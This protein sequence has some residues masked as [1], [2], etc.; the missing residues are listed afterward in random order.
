MKCQ[1]TAVAIILV[2]SLGLSTRTLA[3]TPPKPIIEARLTLLTRTFHEGDRYKVKIEVENVSD[4]VLL[5][6]RDLN[7]ISN[8][9][10]RMEIQLEDSSGNNYGKGGAAFIDPPP[11]ADLSLKDGILRWWMPLEP[12][13]FMGI[14]FRPKLAGVPPGKYRLHGTYISFRPP[15]H[16][17][18][19]TEQALTASKLS[20]FEGTVETNSIYI[21]VLPKTHQPEKGIKKK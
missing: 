1:A 6:G 16:P 18:T 3:Q 12:H 20:V 2:G 21:E 14:Y 19:S 13:T 11:I 8:W 17:V 15:S 7:L 4:H 5:V 10:F 9:P